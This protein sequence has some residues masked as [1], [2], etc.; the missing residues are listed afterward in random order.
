MALDPIERLPRRT[1]AG[2][3]VG[4][5]QPLETRQLRERQQGVRLDVR[6]LVRASDGP[7]LQ[8]HAREESTVVRISKAANRGKPLAR[9]GGERCR[10]LGPQPADERG[11]PRDARLVD[12]EAIVL[13]LRLPVAREPRAEAPVLGVDDGREARAEHVDLEIFLG[14]LREV[15][16]RSLSAAHGRERIQAE[17]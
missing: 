9:D 3:A 15:P 10:A 6:G 8:V 4:G 13:A 12:E 11:G 2:V 16:A 17:E 7:T 1:R 14:F 5:L